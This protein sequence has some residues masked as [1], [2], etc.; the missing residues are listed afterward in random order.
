MPFIFSLGFHRE[1][2]WVGD[3]WL[4]RFHPNTD[5]AKPE[6]YHLKEG[7]LIIL[8]CLLMFVKLQEGI[9]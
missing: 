2:G 5:A 9:Y 8:N 7:V 6:N 4:I 3:I 1:K